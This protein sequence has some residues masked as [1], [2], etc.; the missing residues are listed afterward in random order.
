M[1]LSLCHA[2]IRLHTNIYCDHIVKQWKGQ[3]RS[4]FYQTWF[5]WSALLNTKTRLK[6]RMWNVCLPNLSLGFVPSDDV[7]FK[8]SYFRTK[9]VHPEINFCFAGHCRVAMLFQVVSLC[10]SLLFAESFQE[11][12]MCTVFQIPQW[13]VDMVRST[14]GPKRAVACTQPRRVAAMS[15]AQRVADEMDVMLGQEV[16]YSIRFE[17]CSSAKTV[18]K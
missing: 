5:L 4:V 2:Q 10:N 15:V 1:H 18:L 8:D 13:C 14:G 17:D 12:I 9:G 3:P 11:F 16:G 7:L 6:F